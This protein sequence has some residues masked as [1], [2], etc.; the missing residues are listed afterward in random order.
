MPFKTLALDLEGTL[1]STAVSQL[2]RPGLWDFSA[3]CLA[4][5]TVYLF[6]AVREQRARPILD[7][8]AAEG[9]VPPAFAR[10]P[11]VPWHGAH[12]DLRFLHA[13]DPTI[14]IQDARLVDDLEE[15]ILPAQRH[16][17]I[18]IPGW[19][20]PYPSTDQALPAL[21]RALAEDTTRYKKIE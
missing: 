20:T 15:Y 13:L 21:Q 1:I 14:D 16:L 6:T 12:K 9:D 18:P 11:Y 8:L 4:H 5:F 7:R 2:P 19:H 10:I 3:F 17:W